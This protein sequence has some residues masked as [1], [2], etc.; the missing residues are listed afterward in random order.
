MDLFS[1]EVTSISNDFKVFRTESRF[2]LKCH[3]VKLASIMTIL[4]DL[5]SNDQM[6]CG[7]DR[8]LDVVAHH[9]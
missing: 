5:M 9:A 6:M 7:I 2:C 3:V 8:R 1:S 4:S